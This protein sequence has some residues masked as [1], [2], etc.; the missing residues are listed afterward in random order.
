MRGR[1]EH[2]RIIDANAS[3]NGLHTH[4]LTPEI[5]EGLVGRSF[6]I[7]TH[8]PTSSSARPGPN[9]RLNNK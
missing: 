2:H 3:L 4:S 1:W 8:V 9:W 7:V 6:G 5:I